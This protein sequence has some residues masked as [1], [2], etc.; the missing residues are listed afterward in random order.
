MSE[1]ANYYKSFC[2]GHWATEDA[3]TCLCRGGGWVSSELDTWHQCPIHYKGQLHPE[4]RD[5]ATEA[6]DLESQARWQAEL[7]KERD[8]MPTAKFPPLGPDEIPF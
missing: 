3:E 7:A 6:D 5:N 8:E 4:Y 1:Y 2:Q